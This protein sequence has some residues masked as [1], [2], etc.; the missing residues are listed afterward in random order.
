MRRF[1][2]SM[3]DAK[4]LFHLFKRYW[5]QGST[6]LYNGSACQASGEFWGGTGNP[7]INS[8]VGA[9]GRPQGIAPTI[10]RISL[11]SPCIVEA[12]PCGQYISMKGGVGAQFIAP[13]CGVDR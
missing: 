5:P 9:H 3:S 6:L 8:E 1:F 13:A 2:F 4:L 11:P 12:I 7:W 10:R